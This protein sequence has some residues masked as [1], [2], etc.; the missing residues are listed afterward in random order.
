MLKIDL[1]NKVAEKLDVTQSKSND[2]V[3]TVLETIN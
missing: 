2:I 1:I 3:V